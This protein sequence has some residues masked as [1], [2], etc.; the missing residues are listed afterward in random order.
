MNYIKKFMWKTSKIDVISWIVSWTTSIVY[1][2][3]FT[4]KWFYR[5]VPRLWIFFG[6]KKLPWSSIW[7]TILNLSVAQN[8]SVQTHWLLEFLFKYIHVLESDCETISLTASKS[9]E[10]RKL[11]VPFLPIQYQLLLIK[12]PC[13]EQML[14]A[15]KLVREQLKILRWPVLRYMTKY[16]LFTDI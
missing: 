3:Q 12:Q 1:N 5:I 9:A 15:L 2:L 8:P 14:L 7:Q 13:P 11:F 16:Q 10:E 4:S 6:G